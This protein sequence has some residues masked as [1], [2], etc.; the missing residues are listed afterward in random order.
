MA[1]SP[2]T[3]QGGASLSNK[4]D[5]IAYT[6]SA[7]SL[8]VELE[9]VT[10]ALRWIVSRG[11]CQT[12]HAITLADSVR[13]LQKVK[14]GMESPA[15]NA[16]VVDIHLQ[17]FLQMYCPRHAGVK[18]NVRAD[19]LAGQATIG[20]GLRLGRPEVLGNLRHYL[21]SVQSQGHH[22]I[23]R[24]EERSVERGSARRSFLKGREG[25]IVGETSIGT[26]SKVSLGKPVTNGVE[27]IWAFPS[28]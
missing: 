1:Q 2:K 4:E 7:S 26:V 21:P 15:W 6:I 22:T 9:A 24:L 10:H 16:S 25:T 28:A 13:L 3:S 19:R 27:R 14:S 20:S 18:G 23:Y 12:T 8:T 17:K 5:S 11:G